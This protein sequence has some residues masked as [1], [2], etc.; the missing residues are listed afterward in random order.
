MAAAPKVAGIGADEGVATYEQ[1]L[2]LLNRVHGWFK[3]IV[4]GNLYL[5][6]I[7]RRLQYVLAWIGFI[8]LAE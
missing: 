7:F 2:A 6:P 1:K 8:A 5:A 3:F 4:I